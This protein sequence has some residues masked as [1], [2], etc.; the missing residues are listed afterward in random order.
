MDPGV[1]LGWDDYR[2]VIQSYDETTTGGS[3][4]PGMG[5]LQ[6]C[7][8]VLGWNDSRRSFSPTKERLQGCH[9]IL[10]WND[11]MDIIQS[12]DGTTPGGSFSPR[13]E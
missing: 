5:R 1:S 7:R 2:G 9:S 12:E 11:S 6:G 4:S 13:M 8:S 3:F 10:G